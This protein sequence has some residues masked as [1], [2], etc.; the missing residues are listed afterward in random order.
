MVGFLNG[1]LNT[2]THIFSAHSPEFYLTSA[3]NVPY[4]ADVGWFGFKTYQEFL[5][6]LQELARQRDNPEAF[7]ALRLQNPGLC[8][9][10]ELAGFSTKQLFFKPFCDFI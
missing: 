8:F 10:V 3:L 4:I 6:Y 9:L 1:V 5:S 2:V 7:E